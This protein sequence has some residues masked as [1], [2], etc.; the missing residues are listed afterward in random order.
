MSHFRVRRLARVT[1]ALAM[2][3]IVATRVQGPALGAGPAASGT[4]GE[5]DSLS[6]TGGA[7]DAIPLALPAAGG[8]LPVPIHIRSGAPGERGPLG[9]G[10]QIPLSTVRELDTH[11]SFPPGLL[12]SPPRRVALSLLGQSFDMR[13]FETDGELAKFHPFTG[14]RSIELIEDASDGSFRAHDGAG[15]TYWFE[16]DPRMPPQGHDTLLLTQITD[17]TG[18]HRVELR[19]AILERLGGLGVEVLLDQVSYSFAPGTDCPKYSVSFDYVDPFGEPFAARAGGNLFWTHQNLVASVRVDAS[20]DATCS[21]RRTIAAHEFTYETDPASGVP[22]LRSVDSSGLD[23]QAP[24]RQATYSYG[25]AI[26]DGWLRYEK[27]HQI[28]T[29]FLPKALRGSFGSTLEVGQEA[30]VT[31]SLRD[32]TG[33]GRPDL[34]FA[35]DGAAELK[36]AP[37]A[38]SGFGEHTLG[39]TPQTFIDSLPTGHARLGRGAILDWN[40]DGRADFIDSDGEGSWKVYLNTP[41][42]SPGDAVFQSFPVAAPFYR[43]YPIDEATQQ[44]CANNDLPPGPEPEEDDGDVDESW[45]VQDD[46]PSSDCGPSGEFAAPS[47]GFTSWTKAQMRCFEYAL[48]ATTGQYVRRACAA[49]PDPWT[50]RTLWNVRTAT[51]QDVN[52]DGYPD[53][54]YTSR[55]AERRGPKTPPGVGCSETCPAAVSSP[56]AVPSGCDGACYDDFWGSS[57][58]L[59]DDT[60][61]HVLLHAG[62]AAARPGASG[63]A[64]LASDIL[65]DDG[66][67]GVER[68]MTRRERKYSELTC[69]FRDVNGDGRLDWVDGSHRG[70][71]FSSYAHV[72]LGNGTLGWDTFSEPQLDLP[73]PIE[74]AYDHSDAC[75]GDPDAEYEVLRVSDLVDLTGDGIPDYVF[76]GSPD[77]GPELGELDDLNFFVRKGTGLGFGDPVPIALAD[78]AQFTIS[79]EVQTCGNLPSTRL[80][81]GLI[82]FD[83]DGRVELVRAQ[84]LHLDVWSPSAEGSVAGSIVDEDR[85]VRVDGPTGV[86]KLLRYASAKDDPVL[87]HQTP[88]PE[89]VLHRIETLVTGPLDGD[90]PAPVELAYGDSALH[91][92]PGAQRFVPAGYGIQSMWT[93]VPAT[94]KSGQPVRLGRASISRAVRPGDY[95]GFPGVVLTGSPL[96]SEHL[97][98]EFSEGTAWDLLYGAASAA[99]PLT[100]GG[101]LHEKEVHAIDYAWPSAVTEGCMLVDPYGSGLAD[102][103]PCTT[104]LVAY[105][106]R[107][108]QWEGDAL[109]QAGAENVQSAVQTLEV[110]DLGRPTLT[111]NEGD[112]FD[113]NDDVCTTVTYATPDA[114]S[115][116]RDHAANTP[117]LTQVGDCKG[118]PLATSYVEYDGLPLGT[119]SRGLPTRTWADVHRTSDGALVSVGEVVVLQR[120]ERGLVTASTIETSYG[121]DVQA[122]TTTV[123]RD[124]FELVTVSTDTTGSD[125]A[126]SIHT[127]IEVDPY[128]LLPTRRVEHDGSASVVV[129]DARGRAVSSATVR[130]GQSYFLTAT[131]YLG[132]DGSDPLGQRVRTRV[133]A[134]LIPWDPDTAALGAD[135]L[136]LP[137]PDGLA[138]ID[139]QTAYLDAMGRTRFSLKPLGVDYGGEVQRL[140]FVERDAFGRPRYSVPVSLLSEDVHAAR[141]TTHLYD[142]R[143]RV[144]CVVEGDGPQ[145][146]TTPSVALGVLPSCMDYQY[147]GHRLHTGAA[148][149]EELTPGSAS[150]QARDVTVTTGA[151]RAVETFRAQSGVTLAHARFTYDPLGNLTHTRRAVS[152]ELATTTWVE[153]RSEV[154]ARGRALTTFEPGA[155]PVHSEYDSVG[156]L[157][158]TWF[159]ESVNGVVTRRETLGTFDSLGRVT[160]STTTRL[161]G[162]Q[163][164]V[165]SS[166]ELIYDE[167]CDGSLHSADDHLS[168]RLACS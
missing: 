18:E 125:V 143:G 134:D 81:A 114:P 82:D 15:R 11:E 116:E 91:F 36:L 88:S 153:W 90:P 164:V 144:S 96:Q 103:T 130:S 42:A 10:W 17:V 19:Y 33:D 140:G 51:L 59:P 132:E 30:A 104:H 73:G 160:G 8:D 67:C 62:P 95:A 79:Q 58:E 127:E 150:Y 154:D 159:D 106:A 76:G 133:A 115:F 50:E 151:G 165:E 41:G 110:D 123:E 70:A 161:S 44:A 34:F 108:L 74:L 158:R 66:A 9:V 12:D 14:D 35:A 98:G 120:N 68:T 126:V 119:V 72:S 77:L 1:F 129:Y 63:E 75:I 97:A 85:I 136:P 53:Y 162:G 93:V 37:H 135:G 101:S 25:S 131:E 86:S 84:E 40:G 21:D 57:Y 54:V 6:A 28:P 80:L 29:T 118:H 107:T 168:G 105:D 4:L 22:L 92:H 145:T 155:V 100:R 109:P 111:R 102:P 141:G 69:G 23:W 26:Q 83:G 5:G 38:F 87:A 61:I 137:P 31:L 27:A 20:A 56:T 117:A 32:F 139:E 3:T 24:L 149:P 166:S 142:V 47:M 124:A 65:L 2:T 55:G 16:V 99:H 39:A 152:P 121:G 128:R 157:C 45:G 48:D 71:P 64:F 52:G 78:G 49:Q 7:P 138:G 156:R 122:K 146:T 147:L 167:P 43:E 113:P 89:I 46:I 163:L 13:L 112:V 148:G 94:D 60:Q